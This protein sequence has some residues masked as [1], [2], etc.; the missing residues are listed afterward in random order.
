MVGFPSAGILSQWVVI[1]APVAVVQT[2]QNYGGH[3][4]TIGL[5]SETF[6]IGGYLRDNVTNQNLSGYQIKL[7]LLNNVGASAQSY[8]DGP[9]TTQTVL[10]PAT[11][12]S[13]SGYYFDVSASA[14]YAPYQTFTQF[15]G[16]ESQTLVRIG[17]SVGIV[18]G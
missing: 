1:K 17:K 6:A 10:S 4:Y 9:S 14:A 8:L 15:N 16:Y 12:Y 13:V 5:S 18:I 11:V 7:G 3:T 2:T